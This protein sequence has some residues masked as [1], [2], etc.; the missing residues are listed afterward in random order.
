MLSRYQRDLTI[1]WQYRKCEKRR[2]NHLPPLQAMDAALRN[3]AVWRRRC[4]M[5]AS[6][7]LRRPLTRLRFTTH[8]A[9]VEAG[10]RSTRSVVIRP[11]PALLGQY[12]DARF[13]WFGQGSCDQIVIRKFLEYYISFKCEKFAF[14]LSYCKTGLKK[15]KLI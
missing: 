1:R 6:L 13:R 12:I 3:R 9:G 8:R 15:C 5:R 4:S 7:T 14:I 10:P 11:Q 2:S